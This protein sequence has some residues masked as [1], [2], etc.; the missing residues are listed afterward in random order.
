M[1]LRLVVVR[2]LVRLVG[3]DPTEPVRTEPVGPEASHDGRDVA[4][5]TTGTAGGAPASADRV[6]TDAA[7]PPGSGARPHTSQ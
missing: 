6:A 2:E 3:D 5:E 4:A 7:G 1:R